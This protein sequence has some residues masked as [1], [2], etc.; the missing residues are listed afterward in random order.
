MI[1]QPG[2]VRVI[3]NALV[4]EEKVVAALQTC[5]LRGWV[6]PIEHAV[7]S[8]QVNA[9]GSLPAG[10]IFT[11]EKTLYRITEGGWQVINRYYPWIIGTFFVA[12]VTPLVTIAAWLN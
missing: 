2:N 5:H 6:E 11:G 12:L 4:D 3:E 1:L 9:D 7:P 10:P 8:G